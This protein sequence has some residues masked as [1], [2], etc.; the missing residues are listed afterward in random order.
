MKYYNLLLTFYGYIKHSKD[1]ILMS[2]KCVFTAKATAIKKQ[3][4]L[5][6]R[7]VT[8]SKSKLMGEKNVH[9]L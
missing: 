7:I 8:T 5:L 9:E 4:S 6:S 2:N 1:I 3:H